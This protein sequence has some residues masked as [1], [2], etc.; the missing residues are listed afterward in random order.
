MLEQSLDLHPA[1][2]YIK[3]PTRAENIDL[4]SRHFFSE[5]D[6]QMTERRHLKTKCK[7]LELM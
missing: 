3:D 2:F 5:P 6:Y 7:Q 4:R 1:R